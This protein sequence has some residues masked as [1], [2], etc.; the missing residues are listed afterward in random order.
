MEEKPVEAQELTAHRNVQCW[1]GSKSFLV[2][3]AHL[4]TP[5]LAHLVHMCKLGKC[6]PSPGMTE[7]H[8]QSHGLVSQEWAAFQLASPPSTRCPWAGLGVHNSMTV[9]D[10]SGNSNN[11]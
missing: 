4:H 7:P 10:L 6:A 9:P 3:F 2:Y 8:A 5:L 1:N 11:S